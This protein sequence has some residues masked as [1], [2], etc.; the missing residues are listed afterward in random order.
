LRLA[1]NAMSQ[2]DMHDPWYVAMPLQGVSKPKRVALSISL[3]SL[4]VDPKIKDE[5]LRAALKIEA[6]G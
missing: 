4:D 5:L 2:S 3:D 1:L 6:A